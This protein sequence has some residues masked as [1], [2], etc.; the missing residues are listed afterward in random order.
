MRPPYGEY[1]VQT[2]PILGQLGYKI[3][4]L[5]DVDTGD[6]HTP[7]ASVAQQQAGLAATDNNPHILLQHETHEQTAVT[8]VPLII[9]W[10][11]DRNLK[12]VTVGECLGDPKANW[13][14]SGINL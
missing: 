14:N 13:Y 7:E 1:T 12:M 6:S 8:M 2:L 4:A 3:A 10:A 11:K 9:K 5:W